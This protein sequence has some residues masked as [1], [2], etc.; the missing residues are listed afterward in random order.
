[1]RQALAS[2]LALATLALATGAVAQTAASAS[3]PAAPDFAQSERL[4]LRSSAL[5]EDVTIRIQYPALGVRP[6]NVV[7]IAL[8]PSPDAR[9]IAADLRKR[10]LETSMYG[11]VVVWLEN[12]GPLDS[13]SLAEEL[14]GPAYRQQNGRFTQFLSEELKPLL[15]KELA[16]EGKMLVAGEGVFG[17]VVLQAAIEER[18]V[19]DE[20]VVV[21]ITLTPEESALLAAK[22]P[23]SASTYSNINLL[24]WPRNPGEPAVLEPLLDRLVEGPF[25]IQLDVPPGDDIQV[26]DYVRD[27]AAQMAVVP[28]P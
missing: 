9:R 1:M 18:G 16:L 13:D 25:Y 15:A 17:R 24:Q 21:D 11:V 3:P 5:G 12:A 19:F 23:A 10:E 7:L 8:M 4:V 2:I 27:R 22:A 26:T 6:G 14:A 28:P 20:Y